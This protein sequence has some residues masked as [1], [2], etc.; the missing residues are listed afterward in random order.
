MTGP[1]LVPLA[2][3]GARCNCERCG[4]PLRVA[5]TQTPGATMLKHAAAPHGDCIN[6]AVAGWFARMGLRETTDPRGLL[7]PEARARFADVMR[8]GDADAHVGEVDWKH[9]VAHW[10]LP[11]R[12]GPGGKAQAL[13]AYD[14]GERRARL[15]RAAQSGPAGDGP[16]FGGGSRGGR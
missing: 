4:D 15:A 1:K 13:P 6:C 9:V 7:L 5:E 11:F 2:Q 16:L 10:H 14:D 8:T 3:A 12:S